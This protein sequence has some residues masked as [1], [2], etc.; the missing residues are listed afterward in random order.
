MPE[1]NLDGIVLN[2]VYTGSLQVINSGAVLLGD[3]NEQIIKYRNNSFTTVAEGNGMM[4]EVYVERTENFAAYVWY[5]EV[6]V[7]KA[8]STIT[9]N[10]EKTVFT[11]NGALQEV[12][13]GTLNHSETTIEYT[14]NTF[15]TVNE[16]NSLNVVLRSRET[17]NYKE[18]V[19][20][21]PITVDK[22]VSV[23]DKTGVSTSYTYTG[24]MQ[25]VTG[26]CLNHNETQLVYVSNT[27]VTVAEGN[28]LTVQINAP[29]TDNYKE[30]STTLTITVEKAT[31]DM[32]S[33]GLESKAVDYDNTEQS[34][35]IIGTLPNGVS[36]SYDGNQKVQAGHYE[37][38]A[39]FTGDYDNYN[40]IENKS[41]ILTINKI[42]YDFSQTTYQDMTVTYN[43]TPQSIQTE[44]VPVG[45]D[46][47]EVVQTY[48]GNRTNIGNAVLRVNF[49][50][51]SPNY[52]VKDTD[53]ERTAN[54]TIVAAVLNVVGKDRY[55][56]SYQNVDAVNLS[57][58]NYKL[59]G[60]QGN[61]QPKITYTAK[62]E[63]TS[64][65]G[66]AVVLMSI[67]EIDN[68]N[69]V[70]P[71]SEHTI[72]LD[73]A[74][75]YPILINVNS[76]EF[77]FDGTPKMPQISATIAG[78][79]V[80]KIVRISN[81]VGN[82]VSHAIN[83]D[84]YTVEVT[85]NDEYAGN[86]TYSELMRIN[87]LQPV[88]TIHGDRTQ[89]YGS[90]VPLT[91]SISVDYND[92]SNLNAN[93]KYSFSGLNPVA[94]THN[95]MASF[96]GSTNYKSAYISDEITINRK[97]T[98]VTISSDNQFIY[99]G[100]ER[101]V[102]FGVSGVVAGDK[103][104]VSLDYDGAT[105][106]INPGSYNI[107]VLLSNSNY[108]IENIVGPRK[109]I[110]SKAPLYVSIEN[111]KLIEG[112]ATRLSIVYKGFMENEDVSSLEAEPQAPIAEFKAGEH[113]VVAFGGSSSK[114]ELIFMPTK[115]KVYIQDI[116][117]V[118]STAEFTAKGTYEA[119]SKIEVKPV[120]GNRFFTGAFISNNG[121]TSAYR[122]EI[123]NSPIDGGTVEVVY[124]NVNIRKS[125]FAGAYYIDNAGNKRRISRSAIKD[126][127]ITMNVESEGGYIVVYQNRTWIYV[128][129][130]GAIAAL[131]FV[132]IKSSMIKK[133]AKRS[134]RRRS[135]W[136]A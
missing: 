65:V 3:N 111:Q 5:L 81:K 100:K 95:V 51:N 40:T 84:E 98:S 82:V 4:L 127:S 38:T 73:A 52:Y 25:T 59:V 36:V 6:A 102:A 89:T 23:I 63:D 131:L 21:T 18:A 114:Y 19:V 105:S 47:I 20:S 16:G 71:S 42:S 12:I 112:V 26:A 57:Q 83:A 10:P 48:I 79:E 110:V 78:E 74:I 67:T 103:K 90:F 117:V 77:L 129:T 135:R 101:E 27:F 116:K 43:A 107:N 35:S 94:G 22:A 39:T 61:D 125:L 120:D 46:G 121:I 1:I 2:Y 13:C 44:N 17:A 75:I 15:T 53:A 55:S 24:E 9:I 33:I 29:A 118:E 41:A 49:S 134:A 62:F 136:L 30:A 130:S 108:E 72:R 50:S 14:N 115:V 64:A 119:G 76:E 7:E 86:K 113:L 93:I 60:V 97:L 70:L 68:A 31:Y 34:I 88:I 124:N 99:N 91:A 80:T 69:Y 11:Y 128:L 92:G 106:I 126:G 133:R 122:V 87:K 54:I 85:V 58:N 123:N 37:I 132:A 109:A 8:T 96:T 104:I 45:L 66:A 32:S 28:A 56:S